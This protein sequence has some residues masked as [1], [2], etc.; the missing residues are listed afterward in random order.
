LGKGG[1]HSGDSGKTLESKSDL[2]GWGEKTMV[3]ARARKKD[4]GIKA[5][6]YLPIVRSVDSQEEGSIPAR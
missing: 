1:I 3:G 6:G 2:L 5:R 4:I